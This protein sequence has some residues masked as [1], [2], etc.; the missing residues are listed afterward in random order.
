LKGFSKTRLSAG[1][2]HTVEIAI[3]KSQLSY[4]DE[5]TNGFVTPSGTFEFFVGSS[6]ADLRLKGKLKL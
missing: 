1:E 5:T 2:T 3:P 4:W 6:S